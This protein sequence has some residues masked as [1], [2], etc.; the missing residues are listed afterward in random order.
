MRLQRYINE[1]KE[2]LKQWKD[3][4][5]SNKMLK[6]AV[7]ILEK[8]NKKGYKAYIVGGTVRDIILGEKPH[9]V[10]IATNMPIPEIEKL[11]KTYDIGKSKTFGIVVVKEGGYDFELALFRN[12]GK[13]SD[14]RRPESVIVTGSFE[15]DASRRDFTINAMGINA[16]GEI[17][18]YFD[19][20]KDIKNKVLRT[21]GNPHE[22]FGEDYL[23]MMRAPRFASKL[24]F[25]IEKGTKKAIKKLSKNIIKLSPERIKDEI[26]KSAAQSG[27]KF[28]KYIIQLDKLGI[29][30]HILP[31]IKQLQ[32]SPEDLTHHPETIGKGGSP[33]AH[34]MEALKVSNTRE[35]LKNLA[36]LLHDV[37]K[38]VTFS[39]TTPGK[40]YTYYGHDA[41]GVK[42]IEEI[43]KRLK[44]SN[45][46]RDTLLFTAANHMK[47]HRMKEMKP[48]KIFK[49]VNDDNWD[50][51]ISVAM[52]DE[53]SRG[54]KFMSKKDFDASLKA[55]IKIKEKWGKK[56]VKK[57]MKLVDGNHVMELLGIGPGKKVGEVIR[58]TT[59]WIL[60]MDISKQEEIDKYIRGI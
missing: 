26:M 37:G 60:D 33:F 3:Y 59:E 5:R 1:A 55:A 12:D 4:V 23:R 57:R 38:G 56:E 49:L 15:Q 27:D 30:K 36:I 46:E 28:A 11:Y 35:P 9:D 43:A 32:Y 22:R 34:T 24:G 40:I 14:G 31:E 8:I 44:M 39:D 29:L 42:L 20:K 18:D 6:A 54:E 52:A 48:S 45:K 19:G 10:D 47:F 13:Y 53:F 17:L 2:Q 7:K 41:E 21:V 51:L 50:A 58:K 16:K 25:D